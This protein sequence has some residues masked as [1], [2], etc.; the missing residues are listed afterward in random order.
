M[1]TASDFNQFY[2]VQDPWRTNGAGFR[3]RVFRHR[4]AGIIRGQNLLEL[5][6]GEG[7]L[8]ETVFSEAKNV[9]GIDISDVAIERAQAKRLPYARF[10]CR[11]MLRTSFEGYDVIAA[12]ECVY[13]LSPHEQVEFF[14][15][16][17]REHK[18]KTLILSGPIVG[19]GEHRR[20]FTH[21]E[22]SKLFA[23]LGAAVTFHNVIIN[24]RG[25]LSTL[26]AAI[27]RLPFC[28]WLLDW[29]REPYVFQ[30]CYI[31]RMM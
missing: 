19:Q 28:L 2:A 17:A 6:C 12:L 11:D 31:I 7:H 18:G 5:G 15:K 21:A 10:E 3:D 14:E 24:R 13:Y 4:L 26:A 29:M 22:L 8:T 25:P 20:Y 1:R 23:R 16:I 27:A 9:T 30:R